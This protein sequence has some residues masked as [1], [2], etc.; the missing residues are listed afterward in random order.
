MSFQIHLFCGVVFNTEYYISFFIAQLLVTQTQVVGQIN[1]D[2]KKSA[3]IK[4]IFSD[5]LGI[6]FLFLICK[7]VPQYLSQ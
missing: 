3:G 2:I 1:I 5:F 4:V 6:L 7:C